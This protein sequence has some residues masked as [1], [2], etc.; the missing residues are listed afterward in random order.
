MNEATNQDAVQR[1]EQAKKAFNDHLILL[2]AQDFDKWIEVWAETAVY[3]FP[4][5][6]GLFPTKLD[7]K[8]AIYEA[9]KGNSEN[10]K[11]D[12]WPDVQF[13]PTLDPDTLVVEFR[14]EGK[15]L[16]TGRLYNQDERR[17]RSGEERQARVVQRVYEPDARPGFISAKV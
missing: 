13:Y 16:K 11:I 12:R 8:K 2:A 15:A 3:E 10:V 6:A 1:R 17:H 9:I 4:Y 7:G 5:M 14:C